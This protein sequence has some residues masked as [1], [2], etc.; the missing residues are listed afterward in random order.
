MKTN[1]L[2]ILLTLTSLV[3]LS[4]QNHK[5]RVY[6]YVIDSNNRGIEDVSVFFEGKNNGTSTNHNGYYDLNITMTDSVTLVYSHLGYQTIRHTI[7]PDQRVVQITVV[8]SVL[9]KELAEVNVT[10]IRRQTS[11]ME[12]IDPS[13]YKLMPNS[14]GSFE[15]MLIAFAGVS[16]TNELSSQYNVRGGNFDENIVYVNGTEVYR[17]LLIRA[18][19]QEG[20]SFI[21]SDMVGNVGFSYGGFN[22]E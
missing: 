13:K 1:I 6:G 5:V 18:G 16:S 2:I 17:P 8:M 9:V 11:T 21:N 15:S 3:S 4:G 12:A 19:Q 10:S 22:A 14:S 20:L 7:L